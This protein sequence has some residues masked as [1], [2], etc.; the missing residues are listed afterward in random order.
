M[1]EKFMYIP[2]VDTQN[3]FFCRL[4]LS[5]SKVWMLNLRTNQVPKVVKP[6][7]KKKTIIKLWGLI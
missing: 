4:Q 6:A 2:N 1:D 5:G 3:Y 7:N